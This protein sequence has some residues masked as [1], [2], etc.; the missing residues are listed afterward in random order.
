[1]LRTLDG[2]LLDTGI[3]CLVLCGDGRS[4]LFLFVGRPCVDPAREPVVQHFGS[5]PPYLHGPRLDAVAVH[6]LFAP[7]WEVAA[8]TAQTGATSTDN[9][10]T[11][12]GST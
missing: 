1:M 9:P 12:C 10:P 7:V 8:V 6:Q 4:L 2:R 5:N 11:T 3:D